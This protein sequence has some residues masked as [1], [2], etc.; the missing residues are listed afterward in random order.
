[1]QV[2][3][4]GGTIIAVL[5]FA[6]VLFLRKSI[7]LAINTI[8]MASDALRALPFMVLFPFVSTHFVCWIVVIIL[9]ESMQTTVAALTVFAMWWIFVAA[10]LVR[11]VFFVTLA[12]WA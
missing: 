2:L 5:L 7:N 8:K 3:A 11:I 9:N 1:M 10:C 12:I 4:Y 6:C